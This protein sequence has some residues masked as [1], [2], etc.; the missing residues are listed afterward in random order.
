M[1]LSPPEPATCRAPWYPC[2][3]GT[4]RRHVPTLA[5]GAQGI[6]RHGSQIPLAWCDTVHR[7]TIPCPG[8]GMRSERVARPQLVELTV[9]L[10][11]LDVRVIVRQGHMRPDPPTGCGLP[12]EIEL[13]LDEIILAGLAEQR[14][15][16]AVFAVAILQS[17]D[18][19]P[20]RR[21]GQ[22]EG[23]PTP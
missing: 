18:K 23:A 22:A 11:Q 4:E 21:E 6:L 20:A 5:K 12:V 15:V 19:L 3:S 17:A 13:Q 2:N 14:I 9:V 10:E 1:F 7:I 8:H 16:G